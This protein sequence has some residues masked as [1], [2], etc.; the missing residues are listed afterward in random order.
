MSDYSK[1]EEVP[2]ELVEALERYIVYYEELKARN[3]LKMPGE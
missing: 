3:D 1:Y 2:E